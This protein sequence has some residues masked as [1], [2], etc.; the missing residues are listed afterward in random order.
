[1]K[2][3]I[4]FVIMFLVAISFA[5]AQPFGIKMGMTLDDLI[6]MG[7]NPKVQSNHPHW[8]DITPPKPHPSF[9][10]YSV[11]ISKNY[12]VIAIVAF[13]KDIKTSVYG[14]AIKDEFDKIKNQISISYG[15]SDDSDLL[16]PGSIWD[17]PKDWMMALLKEE[18]ILDAF[19][20]PEYG[21][22]LPDDI[23]SVSLHA[24]APNISTGLLALRYE[25]ADY[26]EA[27]AEIEAE[28]GSV[29]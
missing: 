29:F 1:M 7:C 17:E 27:S 19:W 3:G 5:I 24:G 14:E 26:E 15:R 20:A 28:Q 11:E 6:A 13:G 9:N 22:I 10:G 25:S 4:A 21:S 16:K 12:G 8:Y 23:S 2:K 18:R